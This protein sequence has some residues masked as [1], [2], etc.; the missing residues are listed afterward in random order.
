LA[1]YDPEPRIIQEVKL[2]SDPAHAA[3]QNDDRL[4]LKRECAHLFEQLHRLGEGI[5]NLEVRHGA[6]FTDW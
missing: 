4:T 2:G 3:D 5:V 1:C 6:P